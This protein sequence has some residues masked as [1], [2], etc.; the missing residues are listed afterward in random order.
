VSIVVL[1]SPWKFH[2]LPAV[3][4]G[5]AVIALVVFG[6]LGIIKTLIPDDYRLLFHGLALLI[7]GLHLFGWLWTRSNLL[8]GSYWITLGVTASVTCALVFV[9]AGFYRGLTGDV[10]Y[11]RYGS[12]LLL[13]LLIVSYGYFVTVVPTR[14]LLNRVRG[15]SALQQFIDTESTVGDW[16]YPFS[17]GVLQGIDQYGWMLPV[18]SDRERIFFL[19][20]DGFRNDYFGKKFNGKS[21]TPTL[22]RMAERGT[23]F[24]QYRVQSSWTK[25]STASLFTGRYPH[26]HGV[27]YGGG[28]R[29]RFLGHVLPGRY[30]TLAERIQEQGY[31]NF[32]AVMSSHISETYGFNQGF[33]VWLSP[34][35]GYRGDFSTL[36]QA[37]FWLLRE[38]PKKAFVYLHIK[39]PHQPFKLAY[40]N[41]SFWRRTDEYWEGGVKPAGRYL[42]RTTRVIDPIQSG[43]ISLKSEEVRF[44]KHLYGAQ[45]NVMDRYFVRPFRRTLNRLG[46]TKNSMTIVTGDHG[47]ELYDHGSYAHGQTLYEESIHTPLL[48]NPPGQWK[49]SS[50]PDEFLVESLDLT[51]SLL[52][53]AGASRRNVR[54]ESFLSGIRIGN[55]PDTGAFSTAFAEHPEG[56][57]I[58]DAAVVDYPWKL[59]HDYV[60][61]TNEL[62]NLRKDPGETQSLEG[63]EKRIERLEKLIYTKLGSDSTPN[64]PS[65]SLKEA[66]RKEIKNLDGL[67]YL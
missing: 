30:T 56:V 17:R 18:D 34:R 19:L 9:G 53:Y 42:F 27:L 62:F 64:V 67:G 59:I 3:A 12:I 54:G 8:I 47:E 31:R 21:V 10:S 38:N 6:A 50:P 14:T 55:W 63:S 11:R 58:R 15:Q 39:G 49:S 33:D 16:V 5:S 32:G 44:L 7:V 26:G 66:T 1:F 23:Y 37:F 4:V 28:D 45:V 65:V 46:L 35:E 41:D 36:N 60:T 51:A 24:P 52:D 22:D 57:Y 48:V 61:G 13:G 43:K 40:L 29:G 2:F 25:P 20:L